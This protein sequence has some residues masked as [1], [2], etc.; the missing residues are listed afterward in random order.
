M[1]ENIVPGLWVALHDFLASNSNGWLQ[2]FS[3]TWFWPWMSS[4]RKF[5]KWAEF[6]VVHLAFYFGS[7]ERYHGQL[8][9]VWNWMVRDF[10]K[11]ELKNSDKEVWRRHIEGPPGMRSKWEGICVPCVAHQEHRFS[12]RLSMTRGVTWDTLWMSISF[13]ILPGGFI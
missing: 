11:T 8:L 13:P 3:L 5:P 6:Q 2:N 9:I 4:D 10:E 12:R 1:S 7:N